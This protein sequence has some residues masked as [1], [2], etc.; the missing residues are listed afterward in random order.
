[1]INEFRRNKKCQ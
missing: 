1:V